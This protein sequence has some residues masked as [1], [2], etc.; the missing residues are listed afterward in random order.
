[1]LHLM[2]A[3]I[4]YR[5]AKRAMRYACKVTHKAVAMNVSDA[6]LAIA[7]NRY[8]ASI[9]TALVHRKRAHALAEHGILGLR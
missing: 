6:T 2:F 7:F 8:S 3:D 5:K 9:E 1:M 4:D